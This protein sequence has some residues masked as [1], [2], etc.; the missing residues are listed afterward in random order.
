[1]GASFVSSAE[2]IRQDC[3]GCGIACG[4]A[5]RRDTK[6]GLVLQFTE[7]AGSRF[8]L[9]GPFRIRLLAL[10]GLEVALQQRGHRQRIHQRGLQAPGRDRGQREGQ[11][12]PTDGTSVAS[13][14]TGRNTI[15]KMPRSRPRRSMSA[16]R[17]LQQVLVVLRIQ[18]QTITRRPRVLDLVADVVGQ[19]TSST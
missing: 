16:Q 2:K 9:A 1:M 11:K 14:A 17:V 7:L 12:P 4:S 10:D 19:I 6:P 13:A 3:G 18:H 5:V 8:Q 15:R